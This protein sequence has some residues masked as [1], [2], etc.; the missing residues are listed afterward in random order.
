[1]KWFSRNWLK[2]FLFCSQV[3]C[4][5]IKIFWKLQKY[6]RVRSF[7]ASLWSVVW[8]SFI[9]DLVYLYLELI[10]SSLKYFIY[11]YQLLGN[12]SGFVIYRLFLNFLLPTPGAWIHWFRYLT[13]FEFYFIGIFHPYKKK[14]G[15][16][17]KT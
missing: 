2:I 7:L 6:I 4:I 13:D 14:E 11:Y 5:H 10:F 15:K 1:M 9:N 3:K 17:G 12:I 8:P 16:E